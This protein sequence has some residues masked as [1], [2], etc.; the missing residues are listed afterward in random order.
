M[1]DHEATSGGGYLTPSSIYAALDNDFAAAEALRE[2]TDAMAERPAHTRIAGRYLVGLVT[3]M[4][5]VAELDHP[6]FGPVFRGLRGRLV[7]GGC[8]LIL[9]GNRP[10]RPDDPLRAAALERTIERGADA[11]IVWGTGRDDPE[12]EPILKSEVPAVFIDMDPIGKRAGYVMSDNVG[13]MAQVVRHVYETGRRRIAHISGLQNTRPG[14]DRLLGYRSELARLGL[15]TPP[16][17]VEQG[18]YYQRS[19][20]EACTRL[21]DLPEPPD[22]ITCASDVMAIA[23]MV[24]IEEAGLHVPEDIAV[25]GFDDADFAASVKPSLTTVRQDAAGLGTAAAEAILRMLEHPDAPPPTLV[26]PGELIIR[27]SSGPPANS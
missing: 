26:L 13:A 6:F 5:E 24:A 10:A 8:D 7:A 14:P 16:T 12:V 3:A 27:E 20:R 25:T 9:C 19:A 15:P 2:R 23:A 11:L 22:A 4:Y 17:Y 18:D 1:R 21:L